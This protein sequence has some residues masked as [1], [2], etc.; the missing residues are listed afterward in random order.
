MKIAACGLS[1]GSDADHHL[2]IFIH[3]P[4]P[5]VEHLSQINSHRFLDENENTFTLDVYQVK[6][7]PCFKNHGKNFH[8]TE[9]NFYWVLSTFFV[10]SEATFIAPTCIYM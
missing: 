9:I 2:I 8:S 1:K 4:I 3:H 6:M 5:H 10:A 7:Y